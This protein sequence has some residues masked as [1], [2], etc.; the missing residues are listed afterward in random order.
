MRKRLSRRVGAESRDQL[1]LDEF[2]HLAQ[3]VLEIV[4]HHLRKRRITVEHRAHQRRIG[5]ARQAI[6]RRE[7]DGRLVVV[8]QESHRVAVLGGPH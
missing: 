3:R 4:A 7:R 5:H 2:P 8:E 6:H 1:G